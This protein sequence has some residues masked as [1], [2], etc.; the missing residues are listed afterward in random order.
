MQ[1]NSSA[2]CI[3]SAPASLRSSAGMLGV[4]AAGVDGGTLPAWWPRPVGASGIGATSWA[5][6]CCRRCLEVVALPAWW[7]RRVGAL[8]AWWSWWP[9]PVGV[10]LGA[11]ALPASAWPWWPSVRSS[12]GVVAVVVATSRRA[13]A[14]PASVAV[15][16]SAGVVAVVAAT[17]RRAGRR[18]DK[19]EALG[20][21][22]PALY[23]SAVTS[24]SSAS[25]WCWAA[26]ISAS[27]GASSTTSIPAA[28]ASARQAS[29]LRCVLPT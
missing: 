17:S 14:L 29:R 23:Y 7:P 20:P 11:S 15:R 9:R 28:S 1:E 24:S 22:L 21:A 25:A 8:P 10:Y 13:S 4:G 5:P 2:P 27:V 12:A 19:R 26:A 6:I 16:S 18:Y 3:G